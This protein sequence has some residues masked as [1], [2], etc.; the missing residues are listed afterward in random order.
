MSEETRELGRRALRSIQDMI[1]A[2]PP[3]RDRDEAEFRFNRVVR[4]LETLTARI[5]MQWSFADDAEMRLVQKTEIM[6]AL[7]AWEDDT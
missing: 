1:F 2:A 3:G 6:W 5:M 4:R 7:S